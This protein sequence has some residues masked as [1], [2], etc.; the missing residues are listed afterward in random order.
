MTKF[1]NSLFTS[2]TSRSRC[3]SSSV[4][5]PSGSFSEF[6]QGAPVGIKCSTFS[7]SW[8]RIRLHSCSTFLAK[9]R[10]GKRPLCGNSLGRAAAASISTAWRSTRTS[11]SNLSVASSQKL[12]A[13]V[14]FAL[15][16]SSASY[17][18]VSLTK[19]FR[20]KSRRDCTSDL[21]LSEVALSGHLSASHLVLNV[22]KCCTR[23]RSQRTMDSILRCDGRSRSL[24]FSIS[25]QSCLA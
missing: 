24:S 4:A 7:S 18:F 6:F 22:A 17:P 21:N 23:L 15:S 9:P 12:L 1:P 25:V 16:R 13:N 11:E 3:L 20:S 19:A 8:R 10:S 5:A 2:P 14:S